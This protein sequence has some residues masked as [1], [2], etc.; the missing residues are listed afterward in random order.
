MNRNLGFRAQN[1]K[2]FFFSFGNNFRNIVVFV[3][4]KRLVLNVA[5]EICDDVMTASVIS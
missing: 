5:Q 3:M 4:V 2:F 1:I